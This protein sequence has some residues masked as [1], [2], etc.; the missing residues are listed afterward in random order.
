MGPGTPHLPG[1]TRGWVGAKGA[2]GG[3]LQVPGTLS[4]GKLLCDRMCR[5]TG[6]GCTA[7]AHGSVRTG[8]HGEAVCSDELGYTLPGAQIKALG[9]SLVKSAIRRSIA[10]ASVAIFLALLVS[11]CAGPGDD[12]EQSAAADASTLTRNSSCAEL[13]AVSVSDQGT[14]LKSVAKDGYYDDFNT[15]L[16]IKYCAANPSASVNDAIR[17]SVGVLV[18]AEAGEASPS[19]ALLRVPIAD[20]DGYQAVV[21]IDRWEEVTD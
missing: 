9:G 10:G 2:T 7:K 13:A 18:P 11:A 3:A 1:R 17:D 5:E 20:S 19:G 6:E 8:E 12:V 21:Q 16:V 4:A 15:G 14:F